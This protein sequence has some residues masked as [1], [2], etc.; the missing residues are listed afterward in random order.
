MRDAEVYLSFRLLT[1]LYIVELSVSLLDIVECNILHVIH[2][3]VVALCKFK[4]RLYR[5]I[6]VIYWLGRLAQTSKSNVANSLAL[7]WMV[8]SKHAQ[9]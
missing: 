2:V 7:I 3:C 1:R 5:T 9:H 4:V 6:E 8:D